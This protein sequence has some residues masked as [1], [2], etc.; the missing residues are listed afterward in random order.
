MAS[1]N[2]STTIFQCRQIQL[3]FPIVHATSFLPAPVHAVTS[4][5][6]NVLLIPQG[7]LWRS[8]PQWSLCK[9]PNAVVLKLEWHQNALK[10]FLKH[11]SSPSESLFPEVRWSQESAFPTSPRCSCCP[12]STPARQSGRTLYVPHSLC[13]LTHTARAPVHMPRKTGSYSRPGN[14]AALSAWL[15]NRWMDGWVDGWMA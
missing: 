2:V 8:P 5:S 6:E 15:L 3:V 12:E 9:S 7:L 10:G 11:G 4:S 14:K 13:Y 1:A